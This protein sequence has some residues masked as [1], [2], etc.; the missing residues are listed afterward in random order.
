LED[1]PDFQAMSDKAR[2]ISAAP[3]DQQP[4]LL[5]SLA[6]EL[7]SHLQKRRVIHALRNEMEI[8]LTELEEIRSPAAA[9]WKQRLTEAFTQPLLEPKSA[10]QLAEEA[11]AWIEQTFAEETRLEQRAAVLIALA[12]TG[13]EVR[14]GMAAAWVEQGRLVLRKPNESAYGIEITAP[15][16][17][18]AVQTRV[19]AI[20]N[21]PRDPQRDL[22][23]ESTWC[24]E[25]ERTRALLSEAG[26]CTNFIK[27]VSAGVVPLKTVFDSSITGDNLKNPAQ[28]NRH[29]QLK[30]N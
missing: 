24:G 18:N 2:S 5:D 28:S 10:R 19:V 16:Q 17:G 23:A 27:E 11:R 25:F 26:F 29:Q 30:N 13:Y 21:S 14:E 6:L 4:L 9:E 7:S 20:G 22:E 8:L 15:P 3:A 12:A 1:S